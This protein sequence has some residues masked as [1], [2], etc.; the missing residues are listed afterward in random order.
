MLVGRKCLWRYS[1]CE[2]YACACCCV[3]GK[4]S[5]L[6]FVFCCLTICVL[7]FFFLAVRCVVFVILFLS[8]RQLF[9]FF[10]CCSLCIC[11]CAV[12]HVPVVLFSIFQ[13]FDPVFAGLIAAAAGMV[14]MSCIKLKHTCSFVSSS[15]SLVNTCAMRKSS[16]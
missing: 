2:V 7:S 1:A 10:S 15:L 12:R 11:M 4:A 5:P 8:R 3:T 16:S 13:L 6:I 14:L 9:S